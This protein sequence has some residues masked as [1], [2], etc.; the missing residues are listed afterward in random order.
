[1]E[2]EM[3]VLGN[4]VCVFCKHSIFLDKSCKREEAGPYA[5]YCK[6]YPLKRVVHPVN[7]TICYMEIVKRANIE[8]DIV[9]GIDLHEDM[10]Y[11]YCFNINKTG[12][13]DKF[14]KM[15][16]YELDRAFKQKI[17]NEDLRVKDL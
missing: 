12:D 6:L 5:Y 9:F 11:S 16:K 3:P 4:S 15:N 2:E 13:C 14:E 7:G 1:M 8:G 17:S 10:L